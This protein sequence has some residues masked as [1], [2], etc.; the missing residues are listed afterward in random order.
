MKRIL[1]ILL[2]PFYLF[3]IV[4]PYDTLDTNEKLNVMINYFINLELENIK[5][6]V[7][8]KR[9]LKDDGAT[10]DP[11]KYEQYFNYIQRLKAIHKSR[12]KEQAIID[13]DYLGK[14]GF[15][16]G[17]LKAMKKFYHKKENLYPLLEKSINKAFKIVFGKPIF[18]DIVYDE[19]QNLLTANLNS[20]DI[21]KIAKFTPL[22]MELF[23]YKDR[24]DDFIKNHRKSDIKVRFDFDGTYLRYKDV[25]F[26]F[27]DNEYVGNF[28]NVKNKKIKLNIKINDDI[29]QALKI[30]DKK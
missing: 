27:K 10:L 9:D 26:T 19:E 16:N 18:T 24:R 22:K 5:P 21:Y 30:G 12:A 1:F 15:Y 25:L 7:P 14:I 17:K 13:E 3:A 23:V 6:A 20:I 28:L 11:I 8:K 4:N 2:I 29:F